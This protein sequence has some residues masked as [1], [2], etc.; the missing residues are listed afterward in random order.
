MDQKDAYR[1]Y[2]TQSHQAGYRK[3]AAGRPIQMKLSFEEW[4]QIW[5]ASG[6]WD[7]RGRKGT[8]YCMCRKNDLGHYE[9]G[10]VFIAT[11]KENSLAEGVTERR[12]KTRSVTKPKKT[13][14]QMNASAAERMRRYRARK[15]AKAVTL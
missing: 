5:A 4:A 11:M 13:K 8:Q 10:N 7:Q 12:I 14:E 6:K 3:D 1:K 9:V 2:Y 15:K